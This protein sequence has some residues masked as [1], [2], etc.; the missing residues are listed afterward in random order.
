MDIITPVN[1]AGD[2]GTLTRATVGNYFDRGGVPRSAAVNAFRVTYDPLDLAAAPY[3]LIEPA[4]VKCLANNATLTGWAAYGTGTGAATVTTFTDPKFGTCARITKGTGAQA[5]RAGI[6][7]PLAGLSGSSFALAAYVRPGAAGAAVQASAD[8]SSG[9]TF[10]ASAPIAG[11]ASKWQRVTAVSAASAAGAILTGA[12]SLQIWLD[13]PVGSFIDVWMPEVEIGTRVSSYVAVAAGAAP[14]TRAADVLTATPGLVYSNL[15]ENDTDDA[16]VWVSTT[17]WAKDAYVRRPNHRIYRALQA[18]PA[19]TIGAPEN[20]PLGTNTQPYWLEWE[21]T[22][23]WAAHDTVLATPSTAPDVAMWVVRPGQIVTAL[24]I[25]A[26]DAADVRV[27]E[28]T[29]NGELVYRSTKNLLLKTSRSI[30]GFLINPIER[31]RDEVFLDI[32]PFKNGLICIT[33]TKPNSVVSV[34]D[35]KM[36]RLVEIGETQTE[37]E[38]RKLRRSTIKDDGY[39][40]FKFNKRPS[41]KIMNAQVFID[42]ERVDSVGAI[43]DK[44]T[45][46]LCVIIGDPRWTSLIMLGYVQDFRLSLQSAEWGAFYNLVAEGVG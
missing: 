4:A 10:S 37:P 43:V 22:N 5:D 35:I 14:Y 25:L 33:V 41:S 39:G 2:G 45:D 1:I 13:G 16:P 32:P 15:A 11:D 31:R 18:V 34:G 3:P 42:A 44:Y 40:R 29:G 28:V 30:V 38:I 6:T 9:A 26:A 20:N 24:A 36:G 19:N 23:R 12:G 17:A 21:P 46:E 7:A 8:G 27:A